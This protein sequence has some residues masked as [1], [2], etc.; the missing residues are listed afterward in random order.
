[1]IIAA[2]VGSLLWY[3]KAH[4]FRANTPPSSAEAY[5]AGMLR[6]MAIPSHARELANPVPE[7][8]VALKEAMEHFADHCATCHGNDGSGRTHIGAGM[9]PP[10]PDM[11]QAGTQQLTDGELYYIIENGVRFT[12]MPAFGE[13]AGDEQDEASWKLVRFIRHLPMLTDDEIILM[14]SMNP[15]SP[16]DI[17]NEQRIQKFLQGDDAAPAESSPTHHH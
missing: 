11:A 5:V 14:K 12:G 7:S 4:E 1:L 16:A 3:V 10:P 6:R 8:P 15:K 17:A 2:G 13:K 9:Y